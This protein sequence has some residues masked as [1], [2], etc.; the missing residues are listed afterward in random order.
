MGIIKTIAPKR[1]RH[2]AGQRVEARMR[3]QQ[4]LEKANRPRYDVLL[5]EAVMHRGVGGP[6]VMAGQLDRVLRS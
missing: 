6:G 1:E 5:D 3:R 4:V 2:I